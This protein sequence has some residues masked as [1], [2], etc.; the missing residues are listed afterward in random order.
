MSTLYRVPLNIDPDEIKAFDMVEAIERNNVYIE[1]SDELHE[2]FVIGTHDHLAEFFRQID[3]P[4]QSFPI[5]EFNIFI[6]HY[7]LES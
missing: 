3:G 1:A 5:T 2:V 4:G 6:Q 7:K